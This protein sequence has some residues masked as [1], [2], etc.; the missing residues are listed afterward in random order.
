MAQ[1]QANTWYFGNKVG[2]DFNQSPPGILTN[3]AISSFEGCSVIADNNGKL[4]FYSN[5]LTVQNRKQLQMKNGDSLM[6][7][8]SSTNN[9][10]IAPLPGNDSIYYLFTIGAQNQSTRGLRYSIINIKGDSG[11]GEVE[12]KNILIED[13][14]FE[15][16]AAVKHCNKRDVWITIHSGNT[17]EYHS[18]LVTNA[19]INTLPV[20]SHTGFIPTNPIGTLKFSA[21]GKKLVGVY[22]FETNTVELMQ[23]DNVSGSV[24][25]AI[26]FQPYPI[27]IAD[28]FFIHSYGAEFSPNTNLLYISSNTSD[29]EPSTLFQFDITSNNATA[30]LAS[31]QIIAQNSPFYAGGLQI[32]PD[33]KI[34]MSMWKDTSLS[35]I[36]NPDVYGPGCNFNYNKIF[37]GINNTTPVQFDLPT[38]IQ[39]YFDPASNPYDFSRTGNCADLDVSFSINRIAGIDS[40]KWDFGDGQQS[41]S[42]SPTH[43]FASAGYYDVN[44][45]VYKVDCSGLNDIISNKIWIADRTDY[46]GTDTGSCAAPNLQLGVNA[47]TGTAYLWNTGDVINRITVNAFGKYWLKIEQQGCAIT[48]T[49]SVFLKPKPVVNIGRDTNVCVYKPILLNVSNA[50]ASAYLWNTGETTPF[51]SI[52]RAGIYSVDVT[53]NSCVASDTVVVSWGDCGVFVP[54]AFTPNND[55]KNDE[56]GVAG[57]FSAR[58]FFMEVFDRW[59]NTVFI[60]SNNTQK[61]D[62][63]FKGKEVPDGAYAW[64]INYTDTKGNKNSLRGTVL[65]IR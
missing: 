12:Q 31:E 24:F 13:A 46:L 32:G 54:S 50:S 18:Y 3:G 4:L 51:I 61:W 38:F 47:I 11:F 34:Y 22:S 14:I 30:I 41:Q 6:G 42:L 17:D 65:L 39:S 40:V 58:S 62:G 59:G 43:H 23:F 27:I 52:N 60:T 9:T 57:G 15:K 21:D 33:Q 49:I 55:G 35:V 5:G 2:L 26:H 36:E 28:A 29:T 19:G 7:D 44:L 25:N 1:K 20:I 37:L 64:I 48:D 10:V 56:F 8:L 16:L 53:G 63:R 45:I